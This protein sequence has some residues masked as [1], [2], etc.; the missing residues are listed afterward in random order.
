[1]H[2]RGKKFFAA[3][4]NLEPIPKTSYLQPAGEIHKPAVADGPCSLSYNEDSAKRR[5]VAQVIAFSI[6]SH[7]S[8]KHFFFLYQLSFISPL[9]TL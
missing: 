5:K 6:A 8:P 2:G 9:L 4:L 3:A 7:Y 1:M